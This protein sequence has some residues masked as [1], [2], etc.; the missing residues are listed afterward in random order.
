[1]TDI[2]WWWLIRSASESWWNG[3]AEAEAAVMWDDGFVME[4]NSKRDSFCREIIWDIWCRCVG[5]YTKEWW[6]IYG[7][8]MPIEHQAIDLLAWMLCPPLISISDSSVSWDISY[9]TL[10]CPPRWAF[11]WTN[12]IQFPNWKIRSKFQHTPI[13]PVL[14]RPVET[15]KWNSKLFKLLTWN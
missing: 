6:R 2:G 1:M 5:Y 14:P 8:L 11:C 15:L 12:I 3:Q 13:Y 10:R 9:L 7:N 4:L